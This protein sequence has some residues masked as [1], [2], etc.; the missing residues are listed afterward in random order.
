MDV[1][2][3]SPLFFILKKLD[4]AARRWGRKRLVLHFVH[5]LFLEI[6]FVQEDRVLRF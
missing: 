4:E 3:F 6:M 1:F 5:F 2:F